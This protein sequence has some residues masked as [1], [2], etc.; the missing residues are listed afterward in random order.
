MPLKEDWKKK[1]SKLVKKL[2]GLYDV[3]NPKIN[4][5]NPED[6]ANYDVI[7]SVRRKTHP[8]TWDKMVDTVDNGIEW[9]IQRG[10]TRNNPLV[11]TKGAA[12]F[13]H[14]SPLPH[15]DVEH[16]WSNT[17]AAVGDGKECLQAI[18]GLLR[19]R[20]SLR[21]ELWLVYRQE[22]GNIDPDT[23]KKITASEYWIDEN[24]DPAQR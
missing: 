16:L 18:G 13:G 23:G 20:M 21:K 1:L 14:N 2:F 9:S 3:T 8:R 6:A 24:F 11:W 22:T 10:V 7:Q 15:K 12:L 19:W 4:K 17:V 5:V